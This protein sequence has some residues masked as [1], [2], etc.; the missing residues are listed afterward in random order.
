M[1]AE[2]HVA[3][4]LSG[5]WRVSCR[6]L[7]GHLNRTGTIDSVST[8]NCASLTITSQKA[9]CEQKRPIES[10]FMVVHI[11]ALRLF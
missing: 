6:L 8:D 1:I 4:L 5:S 9:F 3:A 7:L 2:L 11:S 10:Q